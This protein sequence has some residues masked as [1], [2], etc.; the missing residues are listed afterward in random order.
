MVDPR[1][2][3][4]CFEENRADLQEWFLA[5][6]APRV[7][8]FGYLC[9]WLFMHEDAKCHTCYN[10]LQKCWDAPTKNRPFFL[11]IA[12]SHSS[13]DIILTSHSSPFKVAPLSFEHDLKLLAT[14]I[15]GGRES[16]AQDHGQAI[17]AK[18]RHSI[19]R[20]FLVVAWSRRHRQSWYW[21]S[22][23]WSIHSHI[24]GGTRQSFALG[25]G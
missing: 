13:L 2:S 10:Q 22:M 15:R 24:S 12:A 1:R 20:V 8:K 14:L 6:G 9:I 7:I 17:Q 11:Q 19:L 16:Q 3:P 21:T 5:G 25:I 18:I 23:L 4:H